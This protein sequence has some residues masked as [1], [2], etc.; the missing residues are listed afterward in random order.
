[1]YF[2][3]TILT[4]VVHTRKVCTFSSYFLRYVL[5]KFVS[6]TGSGDAPTLAI[7]QGSPV[8]GVLPNQ[9]PSYLPLLI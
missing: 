1:M 8:F 3:F 2:D 5:I 7:E 6:T 9:D 4:F